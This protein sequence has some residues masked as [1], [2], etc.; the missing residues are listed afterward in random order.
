MSQIAG[1]QDFAKQG[2]PADIGT[3]LLPC[4]A[5]SFQFTFSGTTYI[6]SL[7][8]GSRGWVL[9]DFGTVASTVL[10]AAGAYIN[11]LGGGTHHICAF[12]T[13]YDLTAVI[14]V[15]DDMVLEGSGW[16]TILRIANA[17]NVYAIRNADWVAGNTNFIIRDLQIDGNGAN[18][19]L[20][21]TIGIDIRY[22]S[23]F[24]VSTCYVH[25]TYYDGMGCWFASHDAVF[26]NNVIHDTY[27]QSGIYIECE[28]A[29]TASTYNIIVQGN[30]VYNSDFN[31]I[32]ID[33]QSGF[34]ILRVTVVGNICFSN[35]DP[36][37][38]GIY[39]SH[40]FGGTLSGNICY[41]NI[42]HGILVQE[43]SKDVALT[44]NV[45]GYNTRN[46]IWIGTSSI[47]ITVAAN[48]CYYNSQN[49]IYLAT[50]NNIIVGN[51]CRHNGVVGT[52]YG[53]WLENASRNIISLNQCLDDEA[54]T[55]QN[56][57]MALLGTSSDNVITQ[58]WLYNN[59]GYGINIAAAT[60]LA[61]V[62][63]DNRYSGNTSGLLN[64][65]GTGTI[66][67]VVHLSFVDGT[68]S[69]TAD[70]AP[71]GWRIDAATEFAVA[72][73][74]MP[75]E[76]QRSVR[77]KVWAVGLAAPGA[78]N[79]MLLNFVANAGQPDEAYSAEAISVA[80]KANNETAF[81]INDVVSWTITSADDADV[82]DLLAGD[83]IEVK[84]IY[85]AAVAPDIAT[86]ALLRCVEIQYV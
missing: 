65:G 37:G 24:K 73:G 21:S 19:T 5:L 59:G 1:L 83:C 64:D 68:E 56:G 48:V 62:V 52:Y 16:N 23:H 71:K 6:C 14:L 63:K 26:E 67:A 28:V 27:N 35:G 58:N 49:G 10:N 74:V 72:Y 60:C 86:N 82:D 46:G 17:A 9:I 18:Q 76:C 15:Y 8:S 2:P 54:T 29:A 66:L 79:E 13:Y 43:T 47:G 39:V 33:G 30:I 57:G 55:T 40:T 51:V 50:S 84:V 25:H 36:T 38:C 44:G 32:R 69:I 45:C 41:N 81:A 3:F 22:S 75:P 85:N 4:E 80:G 20:S 70:G 34:E 78:G 11:T 31:G 77:M 7:R 42:L 12:T 61:N 53:I